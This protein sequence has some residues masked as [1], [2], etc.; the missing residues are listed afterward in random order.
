VLVE[1]VTLATGE[2]TV[3]KF[4]FSAVRADDT[5]RTNP[6]TLFVGA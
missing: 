4:F 1:I 6:T 2:L 3:D 5:N